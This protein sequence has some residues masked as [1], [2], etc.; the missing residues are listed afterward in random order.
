MAAAS[1]LI[2]DAPG[3]IEIRS[4]FILEAPCRAPAPCVSFFGLVIFLSPHI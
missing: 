3:L 1:W 2:A 4:V